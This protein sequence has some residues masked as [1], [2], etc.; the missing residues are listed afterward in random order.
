MGEDQCRAHSLLLVP[1]NERRVHG[2][3]ALVDPMLR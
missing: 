3:D 2:G 1:A